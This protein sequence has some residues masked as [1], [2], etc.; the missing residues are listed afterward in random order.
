MSEE[1]SQSYIICPF[2]HKPTPQGKQHCQYC[3]S[4]LGPGQKVGA[5][6][7][8]A[9]MRNFEIR[10]KRRQNRKRLINITAAVTLVCIVVFLFV[11]Y[12]TE[13][14]IKPS[15][16]VNSNSPA[17]QWSMF[18]HDFLHSG[19]ADANAPLPQGA[20]QWTF[21][22]GGAIQ[23]SPAIVNGTVYIGSRDGKIYALNAA[24]G[25]EQWEY[26]TGSWVD[27][28][29]VVVDNVVY[30][31]SNDGNVYALD[32]GTGRKIWSYNTHYATVSSVAVAG[33][34]VY[35]GSDD[36]RVYGLNAS[37]GKKIWSYKTGGQVRSSP[38][39]ANGILYVGSTD[40]YFYSLNANSG[41][42]R[43]RFPRAAIDS[44]PVIV[45]TNV[46]FVATDGYLIA[47]DGKARTWPGEYFILNLWTQ[48]AVWG[49]A[50][51]PPSIT[52]VSLQ[53]HVGIINNSSPAIENDVLFAG[54]TINLVA[55]NIR[56]GSKIWSF[57]TGG[58][59]IS[60]PAVTGNTAFIGSNDG[61]VYAVDAVSG[62][63]IWAV[64]TGGAVGSSPAL[65]GG[66]LYVGSYDG[67]VYA[68]R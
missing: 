66:M 62:K 24:T 64:S 48:A 20:V 5:E 45:G 9:I 10:L 26:Q 40:G 19:T 46:Y 56:N 31:G 8:A 57:K 50:P 60:S 49:F 12:N 18:R 67:K 17:N 32:A 29:P 23:S 58:Q 34:M 13:L 30:A 63:K 47:M 42:L 11:F 27:S 22:T 28:S 21:A 41:R 53:K 51:N 15:P 37:T 2:C 61:N 16:T 7:A 1:T 4:E 55:I 35:F 33:G 3:W 54:T 44:S 6:E 52:G 65:A 59:V 38:L 43:L 14:I 39:V 25:V 68:I 36:F